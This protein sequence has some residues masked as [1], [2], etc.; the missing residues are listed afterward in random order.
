MYNK[1]YEILARRAV[2]Y[3]YIH[4]HICIFQAKVGMAFMCTYIGYKP[5]SI[6]TLFTSKQC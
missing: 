1:P 5:F 4:I 3:V 2:T 6:E